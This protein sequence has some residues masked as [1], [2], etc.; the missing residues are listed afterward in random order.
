M[1]DKISKLVL[2]RRMGM[3]ARTHTKDVHT[4]WVTHAVSLHPAA[5][6]GSQLLFPHG[7]QGLRKCDSYP[8]CG[9][10]M[11]FS[12]CKSFTRVC[13]HATN[14]R[15]PLNVEDRR[16]LPMLEISEDQRH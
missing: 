10:R 4:G 12:C 11:I 3:V 15:L 6:S 7:R 1:C 8:I 9:R 14:L 2:R 13:C 16:E 5:F